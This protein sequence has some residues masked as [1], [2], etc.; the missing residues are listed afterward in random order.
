[1]WV[2]TKQQ[3]EERSIYFAVSSPEIT[4]DLWIRN[5]G[6]NIMVY[7]VCVPQ[8]WYIERNNIIMLNN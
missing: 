2:C 7:K 4:K 6:E 8:L 3:R 5:G 1:M